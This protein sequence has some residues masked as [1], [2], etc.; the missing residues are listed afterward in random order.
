MSPEYLQ[1]LYDQYGQDALFRFRRRERSS[2]FLRKRVSN[3]R[4]KPIPREAKALAARL[5]KLLE[6]CSRTSIYGMIQEARKCS[7]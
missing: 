2:V 3:G 4:A 5:A 6:G 7:E 1:K